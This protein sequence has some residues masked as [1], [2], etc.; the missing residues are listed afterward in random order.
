MRITTPVASG[1]LTYSVLKNRHMTSDRLFITYFR[2][3]QLYN[4]TQQYAIKWKKKITFMQASDNMERH[5]SIKIII[6][7]QYNC[8]VPYCILQNVFQ[9]YGHL[10][11]VY[12][13][14]LRNS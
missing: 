9:R 13:C 8:L 4:T 10:S 1:S 3:D 14:S 2:L 5:V 6:D 11:D 12:L 7:C